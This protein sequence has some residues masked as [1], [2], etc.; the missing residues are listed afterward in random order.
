M[1]ISQGL[2]VCWATLVVLSVGRR[3]TW[4]IASAAATSRLQVSIFA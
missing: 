2:I 3:S 1:S 4:N